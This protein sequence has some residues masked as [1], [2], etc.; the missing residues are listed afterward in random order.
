MQCVYPIV[1]HLA[2]EAT[3][4]VAAHAR[5]AHVSAMPVASG[6]TCTAASS[7]RPARCKASR[8]KK[9]QM[10]ASKVRKHTLDNTSKKQ[11]NAEMA[12]AMRIVG[13]NAKATDT[14]VAQPNSAMLSR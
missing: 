4:L 13:A 5:K 9:W 6:Y 2:S 12:F 7:E 1:A 3:G 8:T 11:D 10:R 14:T